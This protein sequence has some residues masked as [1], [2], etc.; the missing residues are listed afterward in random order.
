MPDPIAPNSSGSPPAPT[1][2]GL[3]FIS[4]KY[5]GE[6]FSLEEGKAVTIGRSSDLDLVLVEEMVSRKHARIHMGGGAITIE[7]LDSTNGTFV[8]GEKIHHAR[9][10]EGD[11]VLIGTSILKVVTLTGNPGLEAPASVPRAVAERA[12]QRQRSTRAEEVPRMTGNLEEIPLPDLMQLFGTSRKTGVLLL[13][14]DQRTGRIYFDQGY[15]QWAVIE[16][17]SEVPPL[18][19]IYRMLGWTRGVFELDPPENRSFDQPLDASVQEI[20]ME[21]FRLQDEFNVFKQKLPP[22]RSRLILRTPL[23]APLHELEE[24]HMDVLQVALASPNL[25][26][27]FERSRYSPIETAE[28]L[29][30]LLQRGYLTIAS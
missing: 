4:G 27:L 20:L 18:K 17:R 23:E 9:L 19:A 5:R 30:A 28:M 15:V 24:K 25:E 26:V 14:S 11:R 2:Y 16:S 6:E 29:Q 3:R 21:G 22:M 8:N 13:H 1:R 10:R 7:D 12:A